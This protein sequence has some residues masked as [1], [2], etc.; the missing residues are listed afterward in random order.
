M[1]YRL[2]AEDVSAIYG[3]RNA[4][5]PGLPHDGNPVYE[6][7]ELPMVIVRVFEDEHGPGI[8]GINGR[9]MLDGPDS[10]WVT[11]RKEGDQP[12]EWC[13]PPRV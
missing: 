2:S 13:W 7:D 6:N 3:Q 8:P 11:S 12:G 5:G 1:F 9:V 10:L 4:R